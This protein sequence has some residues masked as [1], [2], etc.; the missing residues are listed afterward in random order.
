MSNR[1]RNALTAIPEMAHAPVGHHRSLQLHPEDAQTADLVVAMEADH[2]RFVRIHHP[3][4]AA[5]T[6]TL[7]HLA[8]Q[9]EPGPAPLEALGLRVQQLHLAD[10]VLD[11]RADVVD[12]AGRADEFYLAC[13]NEI[14]DLCRQLAP[15]L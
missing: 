2:V 7:R 10:A 4:A 13:A 3:E 8:T 6:V 15:R 12:P 14:W 9:L 11:D 1:T 5:R